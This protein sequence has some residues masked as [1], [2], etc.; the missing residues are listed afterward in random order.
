MSYRDAEEHAKKAQSWAG[1]AAGHID[2][3]D[4]I[5]NLAWAVRDLAKAVEALAEEHRKDS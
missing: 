3:D 2:T 5:K 4:K 1:A